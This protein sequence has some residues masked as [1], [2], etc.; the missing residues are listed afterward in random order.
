[1][2]ELEN[3]GNIV[4][5]YNYRTRGHQLSGNSLIS[6]ERDDEIIKFCQGW[7][8]DLII[9]SK[10]NGV[11][12][13]V[14]RELKKIAPLCYWFAD[15]LVT[16]NNEE[17]FEKTKEADFFTC[18]KKN[19]YNV[20]TQFNSNCFIVNDGFDS[21]LEKP[22]DLQ[23][24]YDV[25]FIG[26]IYGDRKEKLSKIENKIIFINDA[27]GPE[28]SKEVSKTKINLN[29][30]T[31]QGPSDRVFKVLA[32]GGFLLTDEWT[33][34]KDFFTDGEDLVIFKDSSDLNE[35]IQ[36][37]LQN[38]LE[39][40]RIAA[41][42]LAKVQE[43][44]REE[45]VRKTLFIFHNMKFPK[46]CIQSKKSVLIAGPWV[47]EFG[48]EL[49][50]WHGYIRSI[51]KY[52]DTTVCVSSRNSKFLY[53]DFCDF[54][55]E[56]DPQNSG[57]R[58]SWHRGSFKLNHRHLKEILNQSGV[59]PKED[60]VTFFPYRKIGNS[61]MIDPRERSQLSLHYV[62]PT[63][64]KLGSSKRNEKL[65]A[66]H[67]RNR[68]IRPNDNWG[69]QRW[70]SLVQ[71]L[72]DSG[73]K[74]VCIGTKKESLLIEGAKD[75][76]ECTQED[77]SGILSSSLCI[78][79]ESSGAMHLASLYCCPQIV[80]ADWHKSAFSRDD[81][82]RRYTKLWNPFETEVVFLDKYGANPDPEYVFEKF[83]EWRSL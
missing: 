8:P 19:V 6:K 25:S 71:K 50:C 35:K 38:D 57:P 11:D 59:D 37:Y 60:S 44:T 65:I 22:H 47:G 49:F 14:F 72:I 18:D 7:L 36:F 56:F 54:F 81:N 12:I 28:H 55:V 68:S 75:L 76:R 63:Y 64:K 31:A 51:S 43:Y 1:L 52:Y 42:G 74:I 41:N 70:E 27:F 66:I 53:E 67:A 9:F 77:L 21:I 39:R 33:E 62:S 17:F 45:W 69:K 82:F 20:A 13:R 78:I 46:R 30:C 83:I 48:W 4:L 2:R 58:D 15:P 32:A 34:R 73:Y 40:E 23:K 5:A 29:F 16:Y 80:W 3:L 10:C 24:Q 61:P 79:G 26:N